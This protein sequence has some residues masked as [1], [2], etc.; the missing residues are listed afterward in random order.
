MEYDHS[1]FRTRHRDFTHTSV[2]RSNPF[3]CH[4]L[5]MNIPED[6]LSYLGITQ[7]CDDQQKPLWTIEIDTDET[8]GKRCLA[9]FDNETRS[10]KLNK[11]ASEDS[12]INF[13]STRKVATHRLECASQPQDISWTS[14]LPSSNHVNFFRNFSWDTT[15]LGPCD[16]WPH[17]L[18]LH[19]HMLFSDSRP[20]AIYWGPERTAIYNENI[21]PLLGELHPALMG[22][23]LE[24]AMPSC[25]SFFG[26]QFHSIQDGDLGGASKELEL[27]LTRDGYLE[28]TWWNRDL[29]TL[30]D[31]QGTHAGVYF[32]WVEITSMTLRDRRTTLIN[33]LSQSLFASSNEAWHRIYE[34]FS[35]YPR[36]ITM[37]IMYGTIAEDPE[38]PLCLKHTIGTTTD[39]SAAPNSLNVSRGIADHFVV[40][41][42]AR[43]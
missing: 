13:H 20:A 42:N 8:E 21:V 14:T 23:T 16:S 37:A 40:V 17:S 36:D 31:D 7:S 38:G 2:T 3:S 10:W 12:E 5:N 11:P 4:A 25:W 41:T 9:Y 35:D 39:Y 26:P 27:P 32:S 24:G 28:E 43:N 1:P 6:C 22:N 29:V 33:R 19:T 18:R 15:S 34:V 30:K